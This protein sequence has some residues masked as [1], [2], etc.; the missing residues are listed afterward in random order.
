MQG[1]INTADNRNNSSR[2]RRSLPLKMGL[3]IIGLAIAF[4]LLGAIIGTL[5]SIRTTDTNGR[6]NLNSMSLASCQSKNL[7]LIKAEGTANTSLL[8][9]LIELCYSEIRSQGLLADFTSRRLVY[10]QQ[11]RAN[12]ILLWMIVIIT[13]SGVV[14]AGLQLAASYKLAV[15]NRAPNLSTT[16]E[17]TLKRDQ[18]VLKSSVT[19]LLILSVS[20][21]FFLVFVLYVYRIES[22]VSDDVQR[23]PSGPLLSG[24]VLGAPPAPVPPSKEPQ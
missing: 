17:I 2:H 10:E 14:L 21:A 20:F 3:G 13:L 7:A 11:Y 6:Q 15:I 9:E 22:A 23:Q 24:G 16:D 1:E 5:V 12:G 19:G 8:K 4:I 18:L